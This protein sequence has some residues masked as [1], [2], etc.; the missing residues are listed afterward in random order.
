VF[1]NCGAVTA[2]CLTHG[3]IQALKSHQ[4]G[5]L[6]ESTMVR[7]SNVGFLASQLC[8]MITLE[9]SL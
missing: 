2:V 6:S 9:H 7:I 8:Q 5:N 4:P 3:D 1:S